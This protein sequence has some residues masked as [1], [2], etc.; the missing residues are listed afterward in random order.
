MQYG[1]TNTAAPFASET[2]DNLITILRT[3]LNKFQV[4]EKH[5]HRQ[6]E[7]NP[8]PSIRYFFTAYKT[9]VNETIYKGNEQE[10][11]KI[12]FS[13]VDLNFQQQR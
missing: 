4:E 8:V 10:G 3:G 7:E 11:H 13:L 2:I 6:K 9:G 1:S 5:A 12:S